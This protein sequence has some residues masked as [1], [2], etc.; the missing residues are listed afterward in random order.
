V[1]RTSRARSSAIGHDVGPA[2]FVE[3]RGRRA[4]RIGVVAVLG[5]DIGAHQLLDTGTTG[6]ERVDPGS[7][8]S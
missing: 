3:Q 7:L 6:R 8:K 2:E 5:G 4:A 1:A